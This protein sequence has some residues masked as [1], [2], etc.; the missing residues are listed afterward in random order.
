MTTSTLAAP[1]ASILVREAGSRDNAALL[2]LDAACRMGARC[3]W[4][5]RHEPDF[6]ALFRVAGVRARVGVAEQDDGAIVGIVT[7]VEQPIAAGDGAATAWYVSGWQVHPA[8]RGRGIGSALA[9]WALDRGLDWGD[10]TVTGWFMTMGRDRQRHALISR[11][12]RRLH[13]S[14]PVALR[15]YCL[16][17]AHWRSL[18]ATRGPVVR[19]AVQTDVDEMAALW[20]QVARARRLVPTLR[21]PDIERWRTEVMSTPPACYWVAC[22]PAGALRGFVGLWDQ[23]PVKQFRFERATAGRRLWSAVRNSAHGD[24]GHAASNDDGTLRC[25]AATH[26][27]VAPDAPD[28]IAVGRALL[29]HG[30]RDARRGG[31]RRIFLTADVSDPVAAA[32]DQ[33]TRSSARPYAAHVVSSI[34][35]ASSPCADRRPLHV[36]VGLA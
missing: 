2:A 9:Y 34:T 15:S 20:H 6:F 25:L 29:S 28:C 17:T 24:G 30:A 10:A 7:M 19:P 11:L 16:R 21:A 5:I 33:W 23:R 26:L 32:C 14:E 36:E 22:T 12:A 31:F 27:C 4:T 18:V 3:E 1:V 13:V 8:H 35:P